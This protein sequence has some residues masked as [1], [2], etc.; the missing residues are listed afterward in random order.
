MQ[1]AKAKPRN[2]RTAFEPSDFKLAYM[3][4]FEAL[5]LR[6]GMETAD[7][8]A[9]LT[10]SPMDL[11]DTVK[12]LRDAPEYRRVFAALELLRDRRRAEASRVG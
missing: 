8:L 12:A 3:A 1:P 6:V 7:E 5:R 11:F 10:T 4:A 2:T 9:K